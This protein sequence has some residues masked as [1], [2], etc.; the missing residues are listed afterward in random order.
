MPHTIWLAPD[1]RRT[2]G[3]VPNS[4]SLSAAELSDVSEEEALA[5]ATEQ[6]A[7]LRSCVNPVVRQ[8]VSLDFHEDWQVEAGRWLL[9]ARQHGFLDAALKN[10]LGGAKAPPDPQNTFNDRFFRSFLAWMAEPMAAYYFARTGWG[11]REWNPPRF[12]P[13]HDVDFILGT[14]ET[15]PR[16]VLVQVKAPDVAG[17]IVNYRAQGGDNDEHV[18]LAI[19]G[20]PQPDG[21]RK[22]GA[23]GQLPRPATTPSLIVVHANRHGKLSAEP[24]GIE[25]KLMGSTLCF[26]GTKRVTLPR[27]RLGAL[28][29]EDWSHCGAVV[30]LDHLRSNEFFYA[31]TVFL[32]PHA[33]EA[34]RCAPE[35]FRGARVCHFDGET[36]RWLGG[37]PP[38]STIPDGTKL[39]DDEM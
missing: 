16:N 13:A 9:F 31:C 36:L 37:T 28:F 27:T 20:H 38:Y 39:V 19:A 29:T 7:P 2:L 11:F 24:R 1:R 32:T 25:T 35:W 23:I 18:W 3:V 5:F 6:F 22:G 4:P 8:L 34:A 17:P 21:T 12:R 26:G 14:P 15:N 10:V 30:L 33:V